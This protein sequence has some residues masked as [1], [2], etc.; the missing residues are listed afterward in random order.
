MQNKPGWTI[1]YW[2]LTVCFVVAVALNMLRVRGG[3][4][5]NYLADLAAPAWFYI[6][7]RGLAP[8]RRKLPPV[9]QWLG[10]TP[11]RAVSIVF[12]AGVVTEWSSR[13]WPQGVFAGRYDPWDIVAYGLGL[14]ICYVCDPYSDVLG[15]M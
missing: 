7:I 15:S 1:A 13:Y 6:V 2:T 14:S 4:L 3:F 10:R 9:M 12:L 11:E 5:T 8:R